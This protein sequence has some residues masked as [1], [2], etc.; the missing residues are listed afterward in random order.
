M[1]QMYGAMQGAFAAGRAVGEMQEKIVQRFDQ[2]R[3]GDLSVDVAAGNDRLARK[4]ARIDANEN[5]CLESKW[6]DIPKPYKQ[7]V[8]SKSLQ[9]VSKKK[10]G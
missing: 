6:I 1:L 8:Q 2:D 9:E 5:V 10:C 4:F 7:N 3:S